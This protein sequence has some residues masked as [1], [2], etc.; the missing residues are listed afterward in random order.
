MVIAASAL[1]LALLTPLNTAWIV[2]AAG[3]LGVAIRR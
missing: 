2:L 1:A 3:V